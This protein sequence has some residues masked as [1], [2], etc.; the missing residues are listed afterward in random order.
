MRVD[1]PWLASGVFA[2]CVSPCSP[3][4]NDLSP[5]CVFKSPPSA[6][7][8][9][10]HRVCILSLRMF[11]VRHWFAPHLVCVFVLLL[12]FSDLPPALLCLEF[13]TLWAT[14]H[15]IKA[16]LLSCLPLGACML[17]AGRVLPFKVWMFFSWPQSV[18]GAPRGL[19]GT[20]DRPRSCRPHVTTSAVDLHIW[21]LHPQDR[22][23]QPSVCSTKVF[24]H[25]LSA[26]M[27]GMR[28]CVLT[29]QGSLSF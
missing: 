8:S 17:T 14:H 1:C 16:R 27:S 7:S 28:I 29:R 13:W 19:C 12:Y 4:F 25:H 20:S 5:H 24:L 26:N 23:M 6:K 11:R 2:P 9:T 3:V 22:L 10:A 15:L 21:L 18:S